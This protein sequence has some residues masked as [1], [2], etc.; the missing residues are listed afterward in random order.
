PRPGEAPLPPGD[1][2]RIAVSDTGVGIA[3]NLQSQV[4]EPF[5]TTKEVG[6]GSGLGLSMVYGFAR[7]SGGDVEL[8]SELGR[9]TTVQMLL[10]KAMVASSTEKE[11]SQPD[12]L[13]LGKGQR[14]LVIEDEPDVRSF[15]I[16]ALTDLGYLVFSADRATEA[17]RVVAQ[18]APIDLVVSDVVL[19]DGVSGP[20]FVARLL[21]KHPDIGV[22]FMTG[23]SP[24]ASMALVESELGVTLLRKPF[25]RAQ[26]A[27]SV[28]ETLQKRYT[29]A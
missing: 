8:S 18:N 6:K 7:Q 25:N 1:Y 28:H 17:A 27:K 4:F 3:P 21:Q 22:V 16:Q 26:L 5:Y 14:L 9:G 29:R 24:D 23:Y 11:P 20:E 19:P 12:P 2:V 15:V 13:Q 10:P